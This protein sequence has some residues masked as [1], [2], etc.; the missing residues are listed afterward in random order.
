MAKVDTDKI[1]CLTLFFVIRMMRGSRAAPLC[2]NRPW[3]PFADGLARILHTTRCRRTTV[4]FFPSPFTIDE[5]A[6]EI[7]DRDLK[8]ARKKMF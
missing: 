2:V 3:F 6:E 7:C 4:R 8:R 1:V 5:I